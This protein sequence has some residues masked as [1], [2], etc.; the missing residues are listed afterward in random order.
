MGL[1]GPDE[2]RYAAIAREMTESGDWVTPRLEGI[3]WFEKPVLYYWAA[4]LAFKSFGVSEFTARMPSG[5]AA[6]LAAMALAWLG[7]RFYGLRAAWA[8]MLIFPTSVGIFA[9]A[10]AATTDMLFSAFLCL[11]MVAATQLIPSWRTE[12]HPQGTAPCVSPVWARM[13]WGGFL[14][15]AALAKGPAALILAG[16][17]IALWALTTRR[18]R[19]G[20]ALMHPLGIVTFLVVALPWYVLCAGRNPDFLRVFIIEHNFQRYTTPVYQHVQPWWYFLA[21]LFPAMFPWWAAY[22]GLARE[23]VRTWRA[24]SWNN[25][26]SFYVACWVAFPIL[27]FS[28]SKSKLPGYI[29]PSLLPLTL[30]LARVL[31]LSIARKERLAN[32]QMS[33]AGSAFVILFPVLLVSTSKSPEAGLYFRDSW[34]VLPSVFMAVLGLAVI[35]F[36]AHSGRRWWGL[37]CVALLMTIAVGLINR[38][39]IPAVDKILSPRVAAQLFLSDGPKMDAPRVFQMHRAWHYGLNFYF[40]RELREWDAKTGSPAWVYTSEQGLLKLRLLGV[41]LTVV[42]DVSPRVV[43]V[44][45]EGGAR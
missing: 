16:G 10:R 36:A 41:P 11:A 25:S 17:S 7:A 37:V 15:L 8:V 39:V 27:F 19:E 20:F 12:F 35:L 21:I 38:V 30:L 2:P 26:V 1:V 29:L 44:R 45:V 28:L 31:A 14:G 40:H 32:Y 42:D 3:P 6:T 13:A 5:L 24:K 9:F 43:L 33:F 18:W 34:M 22:I 23:A 4:A